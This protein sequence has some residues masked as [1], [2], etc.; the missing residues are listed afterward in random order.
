MLARRQHVAEI[1]LQKNLLHTLLRVCQASP[2]P[3]ERCPLH[4][5]WQK[6]KLGRG[7]PPSC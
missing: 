5:L 4:F 2:A 6:V 3:S 7:L 1:V